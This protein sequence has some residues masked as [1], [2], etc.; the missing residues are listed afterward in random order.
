MSKRTYGQICGVARALDVLGERWTLLIVREL[1]LGPKRFGAL[2]AVLPGIGPNLL[3]TR[4]A[5]LTEAGIVERTEL[6]APASVSAYAL[7]ERGEGLREVVEAMAVWGFEL[8]EPERQL[9][10]GDLARGSLLASS[11]ASNAARSGPRSKRRL[12]ANF[13]VDGDRFSV[14]LDPDR[15]R[16]RHGIDDSAQAELSCDMR[17]FHELTRGERAADDPVIAE[18]L[19][20]LGAGDAATRPARRAARGAS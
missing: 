11:L 20:G 15:P 13:D 5:A 19:A 14:A 1:L 3:S 16:V 6:P 7:T 2:E 10:E 18:V 8:I 4:L 9:A 12:A 17:T